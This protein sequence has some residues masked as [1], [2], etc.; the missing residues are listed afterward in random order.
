[1]IEAV[2]YA[3]GTNEADTPFVYGV[4]WHPEYQDPADESLLATGPLRELFLDA[5]RAK[6]EQ[7]ET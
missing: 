2:R 6:R 3:P 5:A 1:V 7:R 4:Q